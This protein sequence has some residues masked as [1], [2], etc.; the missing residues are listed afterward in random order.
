MRKY[1]YNPAD[2]VCS[3]DKSQNF[4]SA[5][6]SR[7]FENYNAPAIQNGTSTNNDCIVRHSEDT[8]D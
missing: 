6:P 4:T 2:Q 7:T 8:G 3:K 5:I 1:G